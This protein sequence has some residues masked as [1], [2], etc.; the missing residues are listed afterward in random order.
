[1]YAPSPYYRLA[2][3]FYGLRRADRRLFFRN[4]RALGETRGGGSVFMYWAESFS[5]EAS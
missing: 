3:P 4:S 5:G 2:G 1:M